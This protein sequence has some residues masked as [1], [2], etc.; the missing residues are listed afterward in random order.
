MRAGDLAHWFKCFTCQAWDCEFNP[1][2]KKKKK[3][4]KQKQMIMIE[5]SKLLFYKAWLSFSRNSHVQH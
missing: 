5:G 4:Q 2:H 1:Q 3:K